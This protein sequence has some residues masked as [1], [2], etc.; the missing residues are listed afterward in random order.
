[1]L[2]WQSPLSF[3][4]SE[5]C[6]RQVTVTNSYSLSEN[7]FFRESLHQILSATTGTFCHS[8]GKRIFAMFL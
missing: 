8:I 2:C 1:M 5:S 7:P 4:L 3:L 6:H